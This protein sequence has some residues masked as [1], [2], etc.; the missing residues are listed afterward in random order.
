MP[1]AIG[2]MIGAANSN[3]LV[4]R[5]GPRIVVVLGLTVIAFMLISLSL[6]GLDTPYLVIGLSLFFFGFGIGNVMAPAA[7]SV[8]RAVPAA[9]AS[10]GSAFGTVSRQVGVALGVGILGSTVTSVYS[11]KVA[12]TLGGLS[13]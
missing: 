12:G 13:A 4:A 7:A 5:L 1:L 8:M 9:N 11:S 2:L 3:R 6:L 10:V